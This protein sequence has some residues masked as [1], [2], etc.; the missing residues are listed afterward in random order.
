MLTF[1]AKIA[2]LAAHSAGPEVLAVPDPARASGSLVFNVGAPDDCLRKGDGRADGIHPAA[3]PLVLADGLAQ[4]AIWNWWKRRLLVVGSHPGDK[5]LALKADS[6]P[7]GA[8][9]SKQ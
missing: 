3:T 8:A 7:W 1:R 4:C 2:G 6:F 5:L 9:I